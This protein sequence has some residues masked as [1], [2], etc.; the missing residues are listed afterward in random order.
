MRVILS[1][2]NVGSGKYLNIDTSKALPNMHG[3][4]IKE[5]TITNVDW[6]NGCDAHKE[7]FIRWITMV[8]STRF[9]SIHTRLI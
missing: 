8:L 6:C 3:L 7:I 2:D 9:R 1:E 4:R 5:I